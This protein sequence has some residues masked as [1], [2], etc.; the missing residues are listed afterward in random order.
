MGLYDLWFNR[1]VTLFVSDQSYTV[2]RSHTSDDLDTVDA[3]SV[4]VDAGSSTKSFIILG[5]IF[6]LSL[7]ALGVVYVGFP[8]LEK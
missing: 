3:G 6:L 4:A 8:K 5:L 7:C 2:L 1:T